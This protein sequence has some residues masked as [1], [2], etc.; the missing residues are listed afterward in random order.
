MGFYYGPGT[1]PDDD[2]PGGLKEAALVILAVFRA[3]ALPLAILFGGVACLL[4]IFF[5]FSVHP[6]AGLAGI[7]MVVAL[8]ALRAL[9]EWRH[10]PVLRE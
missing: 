10:P 9:W 6:V 3:L 7:G 2:K 4:L 1:P 8:V 5:L